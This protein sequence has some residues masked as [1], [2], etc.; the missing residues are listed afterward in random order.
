MSREIQS[1]PVSFAN[2]GIIIKSTPDEIPLTA[3]KMLSNA[4]TDRENS[5][6]VCKGFTRLNGGLPA[7]PYSSYSLQDYVNR[8]WRYAITNGQLYV[9]PV[10]DP[11]DASVWPIASGNNFGAV[12][13]GDNLSSAV[14][15]RALWATFSL[16]GSIMKP[17]VFM[18]DGKSFLKHP[19]GMDSARRVGI[20]KPANPIISMSRQTTVDELIENCNDFS[21]WVGGSSSQTVAPNNPSIWFFGV[22]TLSARQ[23]Y[24]KYSFVLNDNSETFCSSSSLPYYIPSLKTARMFWKPYSYSYE[25]GALSN[26]GAYGTYFHD[27]SI[28]TPPVG[29]RIYQFVI[30]TGTSI[31]SIEIKYINTDGTITSSPHHG[32]GG[33]TT[34]TFTLDFDERITGIKGTYGTN[35]DSLIIVT[36]K[37]E[38]PQY[39]T[40]NDDHSFALNIPAEESLR[41]PVLIA[42]HGKTN[43]STAYQNKFTTIGLIWR[44]DTYNDSY[45]APGTA[46]GWNLYVGDTSDN[47]VKVNSTPI[48]LSAIF[49]EPPGGF[50]YTGIAPP[51]PNSGDISN[52]ASG[53][54]GAAIKLSLTGSG[55]YGNAIKT[56]TNA[57][58]YPIIKDFGTTDPDESFKI[59]FKLANAEAKSNCSKIRLKFIISD[60]PGDTGTRYKYYA[61]AEISDVSG[62][63]DGTWNQLQ[64]FKYNFTFNNYGGQAWPDLDWH[65][66]SA[67]QVEVLTKD[68]STGGLTCAVSFD[69]IWY[70]PIGKLLGSDFQWTYTFYN[71]V[72]DTE[73]D[74]AEPILNT[75]GPLTNEGVLLLFPPTPFTNPPMAN[76]DVVRIY[77]MGGTLTQFQKVGETDYIAGFG[78]SWVDNVSDT[79]AGDVMEEDNQLPPEQVQGVEIW[80]NRLWVHGGVALDGIEEPLNRLRFSKGTRVEH[81][82][83]DNYIYVGSSNERIMRVMEHDGEL[84]VFTSTKPY[85]I[86]GQDGNYRAQSTAVNQG[87]TNKFCACRGTRGL[88]IRSYDGIYEFPNGRKISE[89]INPIFT[90]EVVNGIEPVAA[91]REPEEA[92]GFSDSKVFFS[93]CATTDP[94]VRNDR[95]LVWDTLYER[96]F[97]R[98][99]GAQNLFFE[100]ESNILIGDNL[101]QWYS[102]VPGEPVTVRRSGSYPMRLDNSNGAE[103]SAPITG[104]LVVYGI[105]CIIDTKE[106]D[107]GYP[108]QEKQFIEL[109]V[110]ADTQGYPVSLQASFDGG[111]F[112]PIGI[113]QTVERQ[114]VAFPLIMGEEN[115][116]MAVRMSVRMQFESDPNADA[117]TRIYKIVHRILIEPPRHR[118]FVTDW[119]YCGNPG[120]KYFSQLWV[121]M[122]TFGHPL[123]KI[124]V[125]VDHAV[126]KTITENISADGRQKFY[127]GLGLDQRGTLARLKFF[128]D[129]D[130]EVKVYDFGFEI[131]PEPP[132]L[133]SIQLPWTDNGYPYRKH[134]KHVE[135]DIDTEG[136]LI[137]FTFWLDNQIS[138]TFQVSTEVR[139]KVVQSLTAESFG[140]I[141]RLTVDVSLIGTDGLPQG[142]RMYGGPSYITEQRNPDVTLADSFEQNL[143]YERKKIFKQMFYVIEN[144]NAD[145]VL[146]MYVDNALKDSFTIASNGLIYPKYSVRRMDFPGGYRGKLFRFSFSSSQPFEIDWKRT[147]VVLR[148]INTEETHRRPRLEPPATY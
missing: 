53:E 75:L 39:G 120:P 7:A 124:E 63:T 4:Q 141:G 12:I 46:I 31:E 104:A 59:S 85:R 131:L 77:R 79:E 80:D 26:S 13:G 140:K 84:F 56:F 119:D 44:W 55:K 50:A 109:V 14:D 134:W 114:R 38:S 43:G 45:S 41:S 9:A 132:L 146:T 62:Y 83:S 40:L 70:A 2:T 125:Q 16:S 111:E 60:I 139:Q 117:S 3:Y 127:Y 19:G 74:Y 148:D 18:A 138:Q 87:L 21:Q 107:L 100:P 27:A 6:S 66:V 115:S 57:L 110:D 33:G 121:E 5:V 48:G 24:A 11:D 106:Y 102:V 23:F 82:P 128:T 93:Y 113:I 142:V 145:V 91:G 90:G 95:M 89:P 105:P 65:T 51:I 8:Q 88:Y 76:P 133:N 67:V 99:Y 97:W 73:S 32:G 96:W 30:R 144:P 92:M 29:A 126:I 98:I 112:E 137:E 81:F 35:L 49:T 72:T 17:Y 42:I 118:T 135:M 37:R 103:C 15:P 136:K 130:W 1:I 64:F 143:I 101:T 122:D 10:T 52:D 94:L 68:P 78:F 116:R 108:D 123:D 61:T 86:V 147:Q 22:G 47:V 69:N 25:T 129:G 20:P 28:F 54:T 71:T 36:N 34:N 58:G